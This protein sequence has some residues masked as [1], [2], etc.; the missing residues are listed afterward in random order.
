MAGC[1]CKSKKESEE[2]EEENVD[3]SELRQVLQQKSK[4]LI[5]NNKFRE[6]A[7]NDPYMQLGT[8]MMAYRSLLESLI[9]CFFIMTCLIYPVAQ[10]Y[11]QGDGY[12][13]NKDRHTLMSTKY[14]LG[15]MGYSSSQCQLASFRRNRFSI[16]CS[17][18]QISQ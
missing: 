15:N 10:I 9:F 12:P 1:L 16:K 7:D 2:D 5:A 8:G 11:A 17:Y 6:D 18:G 13:I 4:G 3:E 14:M